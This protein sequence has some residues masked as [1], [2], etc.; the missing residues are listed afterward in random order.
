MQPN[1]PRAM[2]CRSLI[3]SMLLL[4]LFCGVTLARSQVFPDKPLRL[5]VPYAPGG[6]ADIAAR[7]IADEVPGS[8]MST[9]KG[10]QSPPLT[11][12]SP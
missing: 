1:S 2:L 6:S 7:L 9:V 8:P 5:V 3:H 10:R 4:S 11:G 12:M